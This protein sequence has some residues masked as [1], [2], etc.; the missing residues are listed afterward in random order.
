VKKT[1]RKTGKEDLGSL[2]GE[3]PV[4][5][6]RVMHE[7]GMLMKIRLRQAFGQG[8]DDIKGIPTLV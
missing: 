7:G 6:A 5:A 1:K 2:F 8:V 3:R 4:R